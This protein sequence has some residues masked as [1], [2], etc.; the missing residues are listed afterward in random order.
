MQLQGQTRH[1]ATITL[2][3]HW[4]EMTDPTSEVAERLAAGGGATAPE[5]GQAFV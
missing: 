2:E 5:G 3:L 1:G 4:L